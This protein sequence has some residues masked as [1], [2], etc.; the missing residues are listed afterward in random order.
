[1]NL[2]W[3]GRTNPLAWWWGFLTLV[4]GANIAAWFVLYREF[5]NS[6]LGS[7]DGPADSQSMLLLCAAYV[8]G[9]AFRSV[10]PRAD[11]QRICLFNT[12][13]SSVMIG[14]T[15]A[16]IAEVCF[17]AQ[18]VIIMGQLGRMT[19]ADTTVNVGVAIGPVRVM[20]HHF[21]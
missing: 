20:Q 7:A 14:R 3:Q 16:T 11:V 2:V 17:A 15:V 12:W 1:M 4:S 21:R 13:L 5:Q 6:P 9:C 8:F 18:W 19:G 10:L